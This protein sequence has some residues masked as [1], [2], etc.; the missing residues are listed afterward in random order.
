MGIRYFIALLIFLLLTAS[1]GAQSAR[2]VG[3]FADKSH[4]LVDSLKLSE[5]TQNDRNLLDSALLLYHKAAHD[6]DRLNALSIV[7][8]NMMD[9]SWHRYQLLQY[10][11]VKRILAGG[12]SGK[13]QK[14]YKSVLV[15]A[16]NNMGYI[17]LMKGDISTA[18]DYYK[19]AKTI[20][21]EINDKKAIATYYVSMGYIYRSKGNTLEAIEHYR[22]SLQLSQEIGNKEAVAVSLNNIGQIYHNTGDINRGLEY[23]HKSLKIYDEI[24]ES[25]SAARVLNN[26]GTIH[27]SQGDVD[28]A[29]VAFRKCLRMV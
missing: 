17:H 10:N 13:L 28:E 29:L 16:M 11:E 25:M 27:N 20:S 8:Q 23:Y 24:G 9:E 14:K 12:A 21:E 19:R 22:R 15:Q 1:A 2:L 4:Y 7:C 5:L 26:V 6:T 18:T 3:G